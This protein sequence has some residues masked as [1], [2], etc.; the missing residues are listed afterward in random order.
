MHGEANKVIKIYYFSGTGNTLWSA[1][2]IGEKS[3]SEYKLINIGIEAYKNTI[4]L[5]A[6]AIVFIFP[7][8]AYGAPVIVRRFIKR[9]VLK[10]AHISVFTTYGTSPGGALAEI[11][12]ILNKKNAAKAYYGR[13]PAVENYTAM[14]GPQKEKTIKKRL[15][16]QKLA[17]DKAADAV[18]Q[19]LSNR[20]FTFRQL[21]VCVTM[22]F[23]LGIK[24]FYR[25]YRV[26]DTCDGCG[27]C[28]QICPVSAISIKN[29]KP[30]F[31]KRCEHCQ[32]CLHWCPKSAITFGRVKPQTPRYHHPEISLEKISRK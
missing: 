14:F 1:E 31:S 18:A 4:T 24:I 8:Y 27:T 28:E 11:A 2:K 25:M 19:R 12:R 29:Q 7:A 5:E 3:G 9:A 22:L 26:S 30:S 23:L 16:I 20:V 15:E 13:I 32:G 21:S 10:T 6:D 17:T